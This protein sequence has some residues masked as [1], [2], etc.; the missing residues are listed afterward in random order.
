M[1]SSR[2]LEELCL[3]G[4]LSCGMWLSEWDTK[5]ARHRVLCIATAWGMAVRTRNVSQTFF[6]FLN[7]FSVQILHTLEQWLYLPVCLY[8]PLDYRQGWNF[9]I[10]NV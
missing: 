5:G 2:V 8:Y 9:W 3:W 7:L 10:L 4:S 1:N 6:Q